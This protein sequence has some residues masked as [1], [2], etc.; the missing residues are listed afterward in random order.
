AP[1]SPTLTG[2][3]R[4]ILSGTSPIASARVTHVARQLG[5]SRATFARQL[6]AEGTSFQR[7]KDEVRRDHAI[8]L[9]TGTVLPLSEIA[10]RLGFSAPSAF[11]RA[12]R[13]WTGVPPGR[14]RR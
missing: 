4:A 5:L 1:P 6:A 7:V 2:E 11:Q 14:M 8:G 3:L 12:F 13:E 9:L 10:E